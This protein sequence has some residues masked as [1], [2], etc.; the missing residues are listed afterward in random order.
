MSSIDERV[1][2][3][4]FNSQQFERNAAS[5]L[6]VLERL[7]QALHLGGAAK[8]I[9]ELQ[10]AGNKFNL[11][12]MSSGVDTLSAKFS[13]L[14]VVGVTA[15][16]TIA[17]K[18]V[19]S[20]MQLANSLTIS[21][22]K[23]GFDEY[24]LKMRSIQTILANT[25][26]YGTKLAD[27]TKALDELNEYADQ[28]IYNF[29][30]MTA[31]IGR[32]T[33]A[34]I[35]I[36]DATAMIKGFSN[37][38]A[39]SGTSAAEAAGAAQQLSQALNNGKVTL[40]DWKSITNAGMG[41]ANM[42]DGL[43]NIA[44][45][46][47]TV[48]K[49]GLSAKEIQNGFN[50]SLEKGWM[51]AEV[52][53]TYLKVMANDNEAQNRETLKGIGLTEKQTDALIEQQKTAKEAATKVRTFSALMG[54][55]RESIASGWS[56]SFWIIFGDFDEATK[57]FTDANNA[58]GGM[59][60]T[61]SDARNKM[62]TEWD[63]EGG[64]TAAI[65]AIKNAWQALGSVLGPI[66]EAFRN[67]FPA[68]TGKN[69][70]DMTKSFRDFMASL[71][72]GPENMNR[73]RITFEGLFSILGIGWDILKGV[74]GFL[75]GF[76]GLAQSGSGG[77]LSLT[78]A[79][80]AFLIQ[81]REWINAGGGVQSFFD[82]LNNARDAVLKPLVEWIGLVVEAFGDLFSGNTKG[83]FDKLES[84]FSV[85]A[86]LIAT[87]QSKFGG[88]ARVLSDVA[89]NV[90]DFL[91]SFGAAGLAPV[92]AFVDSLQQKFAQLADKFS[93]VRDNMKNFIPKFNTKGLDGVSGKFDGI[94]ASSGKLSK[95]WDWLSSTFGK[96]VNVIKT[97]ASKI[98]RIFSALGDKIAEFVEKADLQDMF[99]LVNT[100]V[101]IA[102]FL[103]IRTFFKS[104]G[105]I[106]ESIS[107]SFNQLTDTLKAMQN[108]V[109]AD[110]IMKI[111]IAIGILAVSLKLLSTIKPQQM[112]VSLG[113]IAA[114]MIMLTLVMK[115]M[116]STMDGMDKKGLATMGTIIATSI[117]MV[118]LAAAVLILSIAAK[119][120]S[121]L[122]WEEMARGLVATGALLVALGLFAKFA[123]TGKSSITGA[124]SLILLAGAIYA[125]SF[126]VSKFGEM[127]FDELKQGGIAVA[128]LIG[129]LAGAS[130]SMG[131]FGAAGGKTF[132][133]MAIALG[134]FV[135]IISK[136]GKMPIK[137]LGQGMGA[138]ALAI[139]VMAFAVLI[140]GKAGAAA[141]TI[142]AMAAALAVLLPVIMLLGK[143][144]PEELKQG[145]I[146]LAVGLGTLAIAIAIIGPNGAAAAPGILAM[147]IALVA[148]AGALWLL[149][150][151][152]WEDLKHGLIGLGVGLALLL[153]AG[154]ASYYVAPGLLMLGAS[155]A[156]LGLA[157]L[158]AGVGM[159]AF[160]VGFGIL[161][162]VGSAGVAIL[163]LAM[164]GLIALIPLFMQQLA[165]GLLAVVNTL[166]DHADEFGE[167]TTK[168]IKA[169]LKA[170]RDLAPDFG[171]TIETYVT[172]ML[173]TLV[174]LS[175]KINLAG[176][177][178]IINFL[179]AID[180]KLPEIIRITNSII[181]KYING[182][183]K[184]LPA[185]IQAGYNLLLAFI[186]G[187]TNAVNANS[188]AMGTAGG[189]LAWALAGG[190]VK[191]LL[192]A[193]VAVAS[194]AYSLA[195]RAVS[196]I[197]S[198]FSI[199]SPSKVAFELGEYFGQGLVNG[200]SAYGSTVAR[201]SEG[202][203]LDAIESMRK[204][205][206]GISTMLDGE[207]DMNPV[208]TPVL[209]LT[210]VRKDLRGFDSLMGVTPLTVRGSYSQAIQATADYESNQ[211]AVSYPA[212]T[213]VPV[214]EVNFNQYNN[215]PKELSAAEI[216]RMTKNQLSL[217]E[218]L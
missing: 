183:A 191:A 166:G 142:I 138:L 74:V 197:R 13:A 195:M 112:A 95:A 88:F 24:E 81:I 211:E 155:I 143:M 212:S 40:M 111:A 115:A 44:D 202:V 194:A 160:A 35:R 187:I 110:I 48:S 150:N 140:M 33:N 171:K 18:A 149:S 19:S 186:R 70:A 123:S 16:A 34:G 94:G 130:A 167:S 31:N 132:L 157:M 168:I 214:R 41:S 96:V 218:E 83:F 67:V 108:Q 120:M 156:L 52:M 85:F 62:L 210:G 134:I 135:P 72:L 145:L 98:G 56:E 58:I 122:S 153:V 199:N 79:A 84:S 124:A 192:S 146:A 217:A 154:A 22:I 162:A 10:A 151:I 126:A 5:T 1:V 3:M 103:T 47:G 100:G 92:I 163:I 20:G 185:I 121:D 11:N 21:P 14:T 60:K 99:S 203:G 127:D 200:I 205:I 65:D 89:G 148:L 36:E 137:Q 164:E 42:R 87:I 7:K 152:S 181:V 105:G 6:S 196:A 55:L 15:L 51:T 37:A 82:I 176:T 91:K 73:L 109:K 32:F 97:A 9:S 63:A 116:M 215:S 29:G 43:I 86:P 80:G 147:S 204:S 66:G 57:L 213:D 133:A 177:T 131:K 8:G 182:I 172:T 104:L 193:A 113:A 54:T 158:G 117:A 90:S 102:T 161:A 106:A 50:G 170:A 59:F 175:P 25:S 118:G 179:N 189:Q 208:I 26:R 216:Y 178:L 23:S 93:S 45:A 125:L 68:M 38:A 184:G 141:P 209:D 190:M 165:L 180:K 198:A 169:M 12:G 76:F 128:A 17:N 49:A 28:T 53:S 61:M 119:N 159:L 114:L 201:T 46:M 207:L 4:K 139:G 71:R 188:G 2:E 206:S 129:V 136:L 77:I 144:D 78:A 107:G 174:R 27:V 30:D 64:R 39:A 75:A 69:L 173:A 101:L